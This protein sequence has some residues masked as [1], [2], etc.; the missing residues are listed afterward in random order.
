MNTHQYNALYP[1]DLFSTYGPEPNIALHN[2]MVNDD[3]N[4]V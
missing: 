3:D 4:I 1:I 2:I